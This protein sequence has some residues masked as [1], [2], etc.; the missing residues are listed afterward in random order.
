MNARDEVTGSLAGQV[1]LVAW[2]GPLNAV[3]VKRGS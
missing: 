3:P 2:A 1:S